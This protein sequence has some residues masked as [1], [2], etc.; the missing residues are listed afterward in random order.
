M[1]YRGI[2]K[3]SKAR[4]RHAE[5]GGDRLEMLALLASGNADAL[6]AF[7]EA[8]MVQERGRHVRGGRGRGNR[9]P[10]AGGRELVKTSARLRHS[11]AGEACRLEVGEDE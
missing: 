6:K 2:V 11:G 3:E 7:E 5:I 1:L 9:E 10:N 4:E 8:K